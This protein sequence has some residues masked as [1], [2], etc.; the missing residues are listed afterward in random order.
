MRT[1]DGLRA[2]GVAQEHHLAAN[3]HS[4][5]RICRDGLLQDIAPA[6]QAVLQLSGRRMDPIA[7]REA[8]RQPWHHVH[9]HTMKSGSTANVPAKCALSTTEY[10]SAAHT[11]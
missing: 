1:C 6:G 4:A 2:T 8:P 10:G 11:A 9:L 5:V 3:V 7:Q